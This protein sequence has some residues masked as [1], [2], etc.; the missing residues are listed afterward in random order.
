VS[1]GSVVTEEERNNFFLLPV[2]LYGLG[3][4]SPSFTLLHRLRFALPAF[5]NTIPLLK[6]LAFGSTGSISKV[7]YND[8]G[9]GKR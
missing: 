4:V 9:C 8:D 2:T 5:C 1:W 7:V 6:T 3:S